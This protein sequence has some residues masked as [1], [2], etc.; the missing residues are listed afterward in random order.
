VTLRR[1]LSMES[2][3]VLAMVWPCVFERREV[4]TV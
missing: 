1:A 4:T 3:D 2:L